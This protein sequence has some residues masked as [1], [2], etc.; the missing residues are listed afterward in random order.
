MGA[1]AA[2]I[3]YI[4][5]GWDYMH[6]P[7]FHHFVAVLFLLGGAGWTLYYIVL[8]LTGLESKVNFGLLTVHGITISTV[9]LCL[10]ISIRSED[11]NEIKTDPA[12]IITISKNQATN[13]SSIVNGKGDTLYSVS[14]DSVLIDKLKRDTLNRR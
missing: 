14:G 9:I 8:I 12:D 2:W 5:F 13:I 1:A 10:F 6:A 4:I 11:V 3:T 7:G